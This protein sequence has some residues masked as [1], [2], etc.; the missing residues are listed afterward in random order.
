MSTVSVAATSADVSGIAPRSPGSEARAGG[1]GPPAA[2]RLLPERL[3]DGRTDEGAGGACGLTL[4][5]F[6]QSNVSPGLLSSMARMAVSSSGRRP[7]LTLGGV[8]NQ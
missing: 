8:R 2:A 4:S 1:A 7:T 5:I 6:V 3:A